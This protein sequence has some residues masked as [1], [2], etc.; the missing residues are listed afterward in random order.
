METG[1]LYR[2]RG[3]AG[4]RLA[5]ALQDAV[6]GPAIVL[7]LPRGGVAV[8]HQAAMALGLPLDVVLVR[9]LGIPGQ[10]EVAFGAIADGGVT[11]ID[12]RMVAR[13]GLTEE[14][15]EA[16]L[17]RE[18]RELERRSRLYRGDRPEA[19][20]KGLTAILVDDG[21]ATGLTME[22]AARAVRER[23][24]ARVMAAAPVGPADTCARLRQ[25]VDEVV[26]LACPD[27]FRSVSS[28][29]ESFPQMKDGEVI[30]LLEQARDSRAPWT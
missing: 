10:E 2:D 11:H 16:V 29:Y 24:A 15:V 20:V 14:E 28:A 12:W 21:L 27:E 23:G 25:S 3:E 17:A 5:S 19:S 26:C 7:A 22:A 6:R 30:A 13:A 1:R 18:R 4:R 9:K 8:G